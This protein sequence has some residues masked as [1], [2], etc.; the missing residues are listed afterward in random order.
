MKFLVPTTRPH[1]RGTGR[2]PATGTHRTVQQQPK[3]TN[4]KNSG[5]AE[6]V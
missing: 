3:A 4:T 5:E 1:P 2:K 6:P